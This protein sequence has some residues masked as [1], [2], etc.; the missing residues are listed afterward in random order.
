[1]LRRAIHDELL[2]LSGVRD[3]CARRRRSDRRRV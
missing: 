2:G 3:R 1:M